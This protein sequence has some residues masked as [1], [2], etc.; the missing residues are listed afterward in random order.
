MS[1]RS[2]KSFSKPSKSLVLAMATEP[3]LETV[4]EDGMKSSIQD[5]ENIP[6][7]ETADTYKQKSKDVA[8]G[9]SKKKKGGGFVAGL[10]VT[11]MVAVAA[12]VY[13]GLSYEN[14]KTADAKAEAAY[15]ENYE[16]PWYYDEDC[17]NWRARNLEGDE[18]ETPYIHMKREEEVADAAPEEASGVERRLDIVYGSDVADGYSTSSEGHPEH[19]IKV[20]YL[21]RVD[22][23]R[24]IHTSGFSTTFSLASNLCQCTE[25]DSIYA[26]GSE[27]R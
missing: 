22:C 26:T 6:L 27:S 5:M 21:D 14:R 13:F 10:M 4:N 19:E 25:R 23:G 2:N 15:L 12:G 18:N 24:S 8:V 7:D 20:R 16:G 11:F 3:T 17:L 1:A 9:R